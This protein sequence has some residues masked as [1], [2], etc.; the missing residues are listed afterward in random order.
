M[1]SDTRTNSV[2]NGTTYEGFGANAVGGSTSSTVYH[3]T[4]LNSSGPGSL[5]NGIGSNRTI[6]FD[7][8]GTITGRFDLANISYLTIDGAGQDITINNNVN[9]DGISFQGQNTHHCILKNIHVTNAG[10]DGINVVD[11]AHDIVIANCTSYGNRDGN[12]D[13]AGGYNVTVQYCIIGGGAAGWSGGMLITASN[14]SIHHNLFSPATPNEVGERCP[15][16]HSNYSPV[17]NPNADIRNNVIWRFGRN[18]ATGSGYGV[19]VAYRAAANAVNNYVYTPVTATASNGVTTSAYG[20]P[21]GSLYASGNVSG[22]AGTDANGSTNHAEYPIPSQYAVTMQDACTAASLVLASAGPSQRNSVDM[23][24]VNGVT[25]TG[26]STTPPNQNPIVNAGADQSITLPNNSVTLTGNASDPDGAI[27]SY[28]W[29]KVSGSGGTISSPSTA[30]TEITGLTA[31]T[32]VFSLTVT[33]NHGATSSDN[34]TVTVNNSTPSNTPPTV[35]A[36]GD[37][38]ITL[39]VNSVTLTG[40]ASDPDGS[41]ASYSWTKVSGSGGTI[42]SPGAATTNI[43][44]LTAGTYVFR[45]TVTDDQGATAT[46]NVTVTVINSQPTNS[47]PNANAGADQTITLPTTAVRLTGSGSDPDG[48]IISYT[49]TK[50]SGI[51]GVITSPNSASTDVVGLAIGTYVF[52]L[53]ITDNSGATDT[54][55]VTIIVKN[56]F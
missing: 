50:V 20:E 13:V 46:D 44:G 2:S 40:T 35:N 31:G 39:P 54:D 53:T 10:N 26:C 23:G 42:S 16:V 22:N 4:N 28:A 29:T 41:I 21:Q 55:E 45:L 12:I 6:V 52:R 38:T 27:A 8:S 56:V 43:A 47:P 51:G 30:T 17:G 14:V 9:G 7:V 37:Q 3:V 34:V 15:M 5:A 19:N 18:N 1:V 33:D 49:W 25:I 48:T 24:Y 32:Y 11:G 36:G